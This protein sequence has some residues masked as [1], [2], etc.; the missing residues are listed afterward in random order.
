MIDGAFEIRVDLSRGSSN[1]RDELKRAQAQRTYS[2]WQQRWD[3]FRF[4]LFAQSW[5][6]NDRS[7][8][9]GSLSVWNRWLWLMLYR[10]RHL[11]QALYPN[12]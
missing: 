6:D 7:T 1:W 10:S 9:S 4:L 11:E 5:P 12:A 2:R 3:D 8:L